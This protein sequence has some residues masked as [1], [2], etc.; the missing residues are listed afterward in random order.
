MS[1]L[2]WGMNPS[3][4]GSSSMD[5]S[6]ALRLSLH[7]QDPLLGQDRLDIAVGGTGGGVVAGRTGLVAAPLLGPGAAEEGA[8][9]VG[10]Q[11]QGAVEIG[12]GGGGIAQQEMDIATAVEGEGVVGPDRQRLVAIRQRLLAAMEPD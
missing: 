8:G 10:V 9:E 7:R 11:L 6:T 12:D 2:Q 5:I 1:A 3:F 4:K